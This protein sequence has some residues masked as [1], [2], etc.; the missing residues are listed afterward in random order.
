MD[1]QEAGNNCGL[2]HSCGRMCTTD[3]Q[4]IF[5]TLWQLK[6]ISLYPFRLIRYNI[7]TYKCCCAII[8]IHLYVLPRMCT[9]SRPLHTNSCALSIISLLCHWKQQE[10]D[11]QG[12]H[13]LCIVNLRDILILSISNMFMHAWLL[14]SAQKTLL[15]LSVGHTLAIYLIHTFFLCICIAT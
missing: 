2:L 4:T 10:N 15:K 14:C 7:G 5:F 1:F 3:P 8:N 11:V 9:W 12:Y 6:S 13:Q